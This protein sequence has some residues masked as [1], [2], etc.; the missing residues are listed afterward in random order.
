MPDLRQ[1]QGG[2]K[3]LHG[4]QVRSKADIDAQNQMI[5]AR[6]AQEAAKKERE[7]ERAKLDNAINPSAAER[8]EDDFA[9]PDPGHMT[10][11]QSQE[12]LQVFA[13]QQM[14]RLQKAA[15]QFQREHYELALDTLEPLITVLDDLAD[16]GPDA[17]PS[18][19]DFKDEVDIELAQLTDASFRPDGYMPSLGVQALG[20]ELKADCLYYLDRADEGLDTATKALR[21]DP[22][23]AQIHLRRASFLDMK[24]DEDELE[25]EL[26]RTYPLIARD[27]DMAGYH[28]YRALNLIHTQRI[29]LGVAHLVAFKDFDT[30]HELADVD[31]ML[32]QLD[33]GLHHP[34]VF[35]SIDSKEAKRRLKR[36]GEHYG[37]SETG[38]C[39]LMRALEKA[40]DTGQRDAVQD[41]ASRYRRLLKT[42]GDH[43]RLEE[44]LAGK[45]VS[46][47]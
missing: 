13:L 46:E 3:K 26:E 42:Q 31:P 37:P 14:D 43:D 21:W 19:Y 11:E 38:K 39:A 7:R 29:P 47:F 20:R 44:I 40:V 9:I 4:I 30:D 16:K 45:K 6:K 17:D 33:E 23:N 36:A 27:I 28:F 25:K 2:T 10:P 32:A 34:G 8:G 22:W 18:V 35:A 41:L 15:G 1:P 5:E 12:M 24:R